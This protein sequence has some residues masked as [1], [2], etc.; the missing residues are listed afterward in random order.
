MSQPSAWRARQLGVALPLFAYGQAY[1]VLVKAGPAYY[2]TNTLWVYKN[3]CFAGILLS[4]LLTGLV[5]YLTHRRNQIEAQYEDR[6]NELERV[7]QETATILDAAADGI[8]GVDREGNCTVLNMSAAE[9]LG[10]GISELHGRPS[11]VVW[12]RDDAEDGAAH[13]ALSESAIYAT[14][15]YG[16]KCRKSD[17]V[18]WR[19]DGTP[20][21]VAYVAKP[22]FHLGELAGAVVTFRDIT[23]QREADKKLKEAYRKVEHAN[24]DLQAASEVKNQF[25]AKMSHEIRTPLNSIVGMTGLLLNT[26]LDE[27]QTDFAETIRL[28]SESLL[29]I[30]NDILDFSKIEA[31]KMDLETQPF[32]LRHCV[33]GA[34]ELVAPAAARK[35]LD[36]VYLIVEPLHKWWIGDATRIRQ[37]LVNLLTNAVKFTDSGEVN[38][39][40]TSHPLDTGRHTICFCVSDTGIGIPQEMIGRL[41]QSFSQVDVSVSRRFGGTGLGLAINKQLCE[42]MGGEMSV[43]SAGVPGKGAVFRFSVPLEPDYSLRH[44]IEHAETTSMVAGKR[45][46]VADMNAT[47]REMLVQ[48]LKSLGVACV[49]VDSAEQALFHLRAVDASGMME[50]FDFAIF[51]MRL[52]DA[53]G[54]SLGAAARA[55]PGRENLSL[56]MLAPLGAHVENPDN[57][58]RMSHVT[59]PVKLT[60][61]YD[62]L[63]RLSSPRQAT[64]RLAPLSTSLYDNKLGLRHPLHILL[65]E[66]NVVNQKVALSILQKIGYR[67]DVASNGQE[68]LDMVRRT[69]YDVVLMDVQMPEMDGEEASIR[70]RQELPVDRQ[71]WIVAMTAHALNGDRERYQAS[72]MNEYVPKPIRVERLVEVLKGVRPIAERTG[73][74]ALPGV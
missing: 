24:R 68:A 44:L 23:W 74:A 34:V 55:I 39:T 63:V 32:D 53:D 36:L 67:A 50:P 12:Y 11:H 45:T 69:P 14:Y 51:D 48:Q 31:K 41:F 42:L 28:S 22:I 8:I 4:A 62:A 3:T 66:D 61:L 15:K 6:R 19:K 10:Y 64:R 30:V 13:T 21:H 27:E 40:V 73:L 1:A 37:I 29:E 49:A 72:G 59:K 70:I 26:R 65:A 18:F 20:F 54:R 46:L 16:T 58:A 71:P 47:S 2:A 17:A 33:E 9:M 35:K 7:N 43:E 25:V 5:A 60:F 38:L 57:N 52:T 56:I